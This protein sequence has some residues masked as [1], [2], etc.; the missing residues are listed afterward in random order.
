MDLSKQTDFYYNSDNITSAGYVQ[1]V[2]TV[3]NA[4]I[5]YSE[6]NDIIRSELESFLIFLKYKVL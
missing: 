6:N 5:D 4:L 2:N 3:S 1:F